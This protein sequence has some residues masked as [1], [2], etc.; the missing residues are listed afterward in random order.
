MLR[1]SDRQILAMAIVVLGAT[2]L[3]A[4]RL[5]GGAAVTDAVGRGLTPIQARLG[6]AGRAVTGLA[7]DAR[8]LAALRDR[9]SEL[10]DANAELVTQN[11]KMV[12]LIRENRTL[13][14]EVGFARQRIDLDLAGASIIGHRVADEPGNVRHTIKLD[15]GSRDGVAAWMP[16][17]NHLGLVGQVART[18]PHWCDVLLINDPASNVE[19]RI[20]R[21]RHTGIVTGSPNGEVLLRY[22]EQ[23]RGETDPVVQTGDLIYTSGLSQRFPPMILIGQVVEVR[24]SDEQAHQEAVVRPAVQFGSLEV[25]LVVTDWIPPALA[26]DG[27]V[28]VEPAGSRPSGAE[29]G[30]A[31]DRR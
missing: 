12:D 21:S 5:P 14:G 8:E 2:G 27:Q 15:I 4:G 17:A 30:A 1:R 26:D 24:Q 9:V 6:A 31:V 20:A 19:G 3:A 10:E 13:R 11:A 7:H 18:A 28:S 22:V 16:V 29:G 25:A 23:D